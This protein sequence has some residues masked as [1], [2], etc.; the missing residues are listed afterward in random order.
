VQCN[1]EC[2]VSCLV[3]RGKG[4]GRAAI[5]IRKISGLAVDTMT[6]VVHWAM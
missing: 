4:Q 6:P 2:A 3:K 5:I 1:G